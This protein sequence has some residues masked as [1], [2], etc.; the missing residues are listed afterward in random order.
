MATKKTTKK[1]AGGSSSKGKGLSN[2]EKAEIGAG[3]LAAA[4]AAGAAGYYFYG[5]DK[6]SKHRKAASAWAKGLKKDVLKRAKDLKKID[7]KAIGKVVDEAV[8]AYQGVRGVTT[9]DLK[10]AAKELKRNWQA[11]KGEAGSA[12]KTAKKTAKKT[13]ATAKKGVKK[14]TSAAKKATKGG[15]R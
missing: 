7:A 2:L 10:A 1:S 15:K 13:V 11:V 12:G 4:V 3:V 6:A 5:S 14:A 8:D 9:A